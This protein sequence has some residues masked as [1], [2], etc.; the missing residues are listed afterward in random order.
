MNLDRLYI[1][2][3]IDWADDDVLSFVLEMLER[4]D[5]KATFFVTHD[6][7]VIAQMK[8]DRRIERAIHPNFNPLLE[9]PATIE[10][11]SAARILQELKDIV[12]EAVACRSHSL[13]TGTPLLRLC[14]E[15][16]LLI[17]SNVYIPCRRVPNVRPW[18]FW[19]GSLIVPF[20]WSDYID[21]LRGGDAEPAHVLSAPETIK[22]VAFHPVH[23]YLNT[24]D[25]DHYTQFK[26][27]GLSAR[28]ARQRLQNDRPGVGDA[29][30][31]LLEAVSADGIQ[32]GLLADLLDLF[33]DNSGHNA[34]R[35]SATL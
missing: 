19:T 33:P 31:R 26:Q 10:P 3:D 24:S 29:F 35:V 5:C 12:P 8:D 6:S 23:V 1:T 17:D 32:T 27:S 28:E 21:M 22:V 20:V 30:R 14:Y 4:C 11:G 15:Q 16:G 25:L 2:L 7:P 13:V 18:R 34:D 9:A